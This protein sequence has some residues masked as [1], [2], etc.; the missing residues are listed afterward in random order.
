MSIRGLSDA[1]LLLLLSTFSHL[2][3]CQLRPRVYI[4]T[5]DGVG[6]TKK[7]IFGQENRDNCSHLEL[8]FPGLRVGSLPGNCP[9]LPSIS[10]PPVHITSIFFVTQIDN[11]YNL[12]ISFPLQGKGFEVLSTTHGPLV[13]GMNK[14]I[15]SYTKQS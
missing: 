14:E 5:G 9:L 3:L 6:W 12:K 4:G 15:M 11:Y 13:Y 2:Y 8:W 10:L 7:V 1:Q